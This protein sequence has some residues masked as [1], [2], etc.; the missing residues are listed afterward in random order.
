MQQNYALKTV[1]I[2]YPGYTNAELS[3]L[4]HLQITSTKQMPDKQE[5]KLEPA[6][7]DERN[8][9]RPKSREEQ[10]KTPESP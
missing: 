1:S 9:T 6:D 2:G 4:E 10:H 5:T 8:C 7:T 3:D